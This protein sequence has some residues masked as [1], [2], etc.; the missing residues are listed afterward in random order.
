MKKPI[1]KYL[2]AEIKT[3]SMP[4]NME[5]ILIKSIVLLAKYS[6]ILNIIVN[7]KIKK[8]RPIYFKLE[9]K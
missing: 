3:L 1:S 9:T 5:L 2:I 8:Q 4:L 7:W 6:V